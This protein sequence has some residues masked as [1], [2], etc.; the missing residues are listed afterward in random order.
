MSLQGALLVFAGGC[1]ALVAG[2]L[3]DRWKRWRQE[4]GKVPWA[5]IRAF[6]AWGATATNV[7]HALV[8]VS[9]HDIAESGLICPVCRTQAAE[10]GDFSRVRRTK[11]NGDE[12]E[13]IECFGEREV[14]DGREVPCGTY[15]AASPD[16]EHG[17]HLDDHGNIVAQVKQEPPEHFRFV[18]IP[19]DRVLREQYGEDVVA[20]I[21]AD[22][23]ET[24]TVNEDKR[25][26][27]RVARTNKHDVLVGDELLSAIRRDLD[28]RTP[29][30]PHPALPADT[31]PLEPK[32]KD[33]RLV[34]TQKLPA[35]TERDLVTAPPT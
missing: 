11:I 2:R 25:P 16:T 17:D 26:T 23:D 4:C 7:K 9:R 19:R 35:L 18:R 24:L 32:P 10:R 33:P 13:V 8:C 30:H 22:G 28:A 20:A 1:A 15:L 31:V 29:P 27:E 6:N 21:D 5:P 12:N 34:D 3:I 14:E